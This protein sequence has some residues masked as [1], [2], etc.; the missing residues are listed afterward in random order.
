MNNSDHKATFSIIMTVYDDARQL[1]ENLPLFL[2]QEYEPADYEVIV[3]DESST[4]DTTDVLKLMKA[5]YAHLYSTFL[6]KP[7]RLVTRLRLALTLGVKAAKHDWLIFTDIHTPPPSPQWLNELSAFTTGSTSLLLGYINRKTGDVRLQPF[8][9]VGEARLV[10]S[11]TERKRANGHNGRML[12]YVRGK[13]DFVVVRREY[14][15]ETLRF[16]ERDIRGMKLL[17]RRIGIFVHNMFH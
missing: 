3:V 9:S 5:K 4:D 15:H 7:N 10:I 14:G 8:D 2:E 12:R 6:P 17:G 1:E 13:Y 16:F 11:Q